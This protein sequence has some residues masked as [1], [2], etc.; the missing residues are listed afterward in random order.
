MTADG[1]RV[2]L[3]L[4]AVIAAAVA[5]TLIEGAPARLPGVALGSTVLL[6]VERAAAL[7]A[8]SVA[9]ISVLAQAARGR[10]PTQLSTSGIAYDAE[11]TRATA[12]AL[13]EL[14]HE[15]DRHQAALDGLAERLDALAPKS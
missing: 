1:R 15:V 14:Q 4:A 2:A 8:I 6:H 5:V 13:A 12:T 10:L 11:E 3:P 7:F 9:V